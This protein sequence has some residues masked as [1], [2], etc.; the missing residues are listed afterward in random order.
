M[1]INVRIHNS[2][3]SGANVLKAESI[4]LDVEA[5]V[6]VCGDVHGQFFDLLKVNYYIHIEINSIE[7]TTYS[8]STYWAKGLT[9]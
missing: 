3:H 9:L 7:D 5:P 4:M 8:K 2:F 1:Y 6:T